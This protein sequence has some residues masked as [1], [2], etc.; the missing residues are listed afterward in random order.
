L[1]W[2]GG[3]LQRGRVR[4]AGHGAGVCRLGSALAV[5]FTLGLALLFAAGLS[6]AQAPE[7]NGW[8]GKRVVKKYR[9]LTLSLD[10]RT[11]NWTQEVTIYRVDQIKGR[12]LKLYAVGSR[13][14]WTL[15]EH[16]VPVEQAT[17]FFTN[18]IGARARDSHGYRMRAEVRSDRKELDLALQDFNE[19]IALDP[20]NA[21]LYNLRGCIWDDKKSYDKAIA[22]FDEAIRLDPRWASAYDNRGN[23]WSRMKKYDKAIT[24][25]N[26]AIRLDPEIPRALLLM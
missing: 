20:T 2:L 15:A 9:Y 11:I 25:H 12:W 4:C 13:G 26:E 16:V 22:D 6:A 10:D 3:R 24:D 14:G 8:L 23:T 5:L 7:E 18:Y 21:A 19:A 1:F 17:E